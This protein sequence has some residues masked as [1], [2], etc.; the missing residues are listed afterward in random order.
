MLHGG[1]SG[2]EQRRALA[3]FFDGDADALLA[4]DVA[5]QGL[6][7]QHRA[8]WVVLRS[9]VD[10]DALGT[11]RRARRSHRPDSPSA[12]HRD[13]CPSSGPNGGAAAGGNTTTG[14]RQRAAAQPCRTRAAEGLARLFARQRALAARWRGPDPSAVPCTRVRASTPR[15]LGLEPRDRDV[16]SYYTIVRSRSSRSRSSRKLAR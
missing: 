8:R 14:Q 11:A 12:R 2:S 1:L 13:R 4:T 7:L 16:P 15:A 9:A 10:T 6:N 5:S 3:R